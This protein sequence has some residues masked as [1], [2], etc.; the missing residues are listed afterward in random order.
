MNSVS[1]DWKLCY[2]LHREQK[3]CRKHGGQPNQ[4]GVIHIRFSVTLLVSPAHCR[5]HSCSISLCL[6]RHIP[7]MTIISKYLK[8]T[9]QY[10]SNISHVYPTPPTRATTLFRQ[11][12]H[13]AIILITPLSKA[14]VIQATVLYCIYKFK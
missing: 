11:S 14:L 13:K 12:C 7:K 1:I 8:I 5:F 3:N 6:T 2:G 4:V 9:V 10:N